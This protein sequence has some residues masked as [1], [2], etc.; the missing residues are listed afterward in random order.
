MGHMENF[1]AKAE[2]NKQVDLINARA[3]NWWLW[4]VMVPAGLI[5]ALWPVYQWVLSLPHAFQRAFAHGDFVLLSA[6]I[7]LELTVES[8]QLAWQRLSFRAVAGSGKAGAV[9]LMFVYGFIK[10]DV[11]IQESRLP[12]AKGAALQSAILA[13]LRAYACFNCSVIVLA[14]GACAF[15][16]WSLLEHQRQEQLDRFGLV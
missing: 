13:K 15:V 14:V 11:I 2:F 1:R 4:K 8:E 7:L 3:V 5:A 16:L 10:Y 9:I 6:L 12:G